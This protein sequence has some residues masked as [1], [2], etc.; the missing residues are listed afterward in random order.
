MAL[1]PI[2]GLKIPDPL[3]TGAQPETV[4]STAPGLV[5]SAATQPTVTAQ[6]PTGA[7][8]VSTYGVTPGAAATAAP[9]TRAVQ[10]N[11][12][13]QGQIAGLIDKNSPLLQ[14]ARNQATMA[15]NARGL[16]NSSIA[17]SA[18]ESAAYGAALPIAQADARAYEQAARDQ[19]ALLSQTS[20]FNAGQSNEMARATLAAQTQ[21]EQF[22]AE[23][24]NRILS[25]NLDAANKTQLATI[26]ANYKT[27]M[28]SSASASDIY[29]QSLANIT[30]ITMSKD[31]DPTAKQAAVNQQVEL[32]KDGM[33]V[34]SSINGLN[35]QNILT[36]A[37]TP[38]PVAAPAQ[39]SAP[40][41]ANGN[42]Y[43][44]YSSQ[45]FYYEQRNR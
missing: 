20:Q 44:P 34:S 30:N 22:N 3:T 21:A 1:D 19:Q 17:A 25:Q 11:E 13:V 43:P 38:I 9:S 23:S 6:A 12:T 14:Q 8:A 10:S 33:A 5:S 36:F 45:W 27:L 41:S 35:L 39:Q 32:L 26:E 2:T 29:K 42:P 31:M 15:S 16:V 37:E 4:Q 28:Q 40:V 7:P 24:Q 18:G